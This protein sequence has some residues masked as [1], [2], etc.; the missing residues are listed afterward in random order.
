MRRGGEYAGLGAGMRPD[1]ECTRLGPGERVVRVV[2]LVPVVPVVPVAQ[3]VPG[4]PGVPGVLVWLLTLTVLS[5][6]LMGCEEVSPGPPPR[7]YRVEEGL[8]RDREGHV[9]LLRGMNV[10][11]VAKSTP[12]HL[13]DLGPGDVDELLGGGVN[14]V[15]LL[16]FWKAITPEGPGLVDEGYLAAFRA[17][18][19]LLAGAGIYVVVD[20]HQDLWGVPFAPHGAPGWA[21]PEEITAGY[22]PTSP[23]WLNYTRPQVLGCFDHFWSS[24]SAPQLQEAFTAAW[25]AVA[26]AVC[27]EELVLGFDLLN[28]PYPGSALFEAEWDN[29]VLLPF[30]LRVAEAVEAACPG[31]LM[32]IEPSA[33]YVLGMASPMEVPVDERHRLV[34]AGHFYPTAVHEPGETGYDGDAT[35]LEREVLDLFGPYLEQDVAVWIGEWGGITTNPGFEDYVSDVSAIFAAHNL[36]AAFWDYY[37]SDGG[38]AFL[39]GE[40][41][42]KPELRGGFGL[43]MPTRLPG[44]P[45]VTLSPENSRLTASFRCQVGREASVLL[46]AASCACASSPEGVLGPMADGPGFVAASCARNDPVTLSCHCAP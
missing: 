27:S 45:E 31:R 46:P 17:Q 8:M 1:G 6:G 13:F 12:D 18:V 25:V 22:E 33:G 42:R 10:S 35:A 34:Y 28:E 14:V 39:D 24:P 7:L 29:E 38:F 43:P 21:C 3:V 19:D 40:G 15:R 37:Q 44:A 20:M 32:F 16:T 23:W 41:R 11:G 2:P 4:V 26:Q 9:L 30:Y 36:S 5:G